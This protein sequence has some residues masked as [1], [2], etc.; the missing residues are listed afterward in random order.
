LWCDALRLIC[1]SSNEAAALLLAAGAH[2]KAR[3]DFEPT[4]DEIA[5]A[6]RRIARERV[7]LIR[8]RAF[9][10]CVALESLELPALLMCEILEFACAPF[11]AC[12]PFHHKWN[13]RRG[14]EASRAVR[15]MVVSEITIIVDVW[16]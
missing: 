16:R 10:V 1:A 8:A 7:D 5:E 11:A 13:I 2:R 15:T 9:E 6:R 4:A 12:V 14:C 3:C